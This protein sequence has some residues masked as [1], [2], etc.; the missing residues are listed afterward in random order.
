MANGGAPGFAPCW[1]AVTRW[2][3][4]HHLIAKPRPY[5]ASPTPA[6]LVR[7]G[8]GGC[9]H[10]PRGECDQGGF[11]RRHQGGFER[12]HAVESCG[13]S[14]TY[15][16]I[17]AFAPSFADRCDD[18]PDR[19]VKSSVKFNVHKD[20]PAPI[21]GERTAVAP[22]HRREPC[23]SRRVAVLGRRSPVCC[24][25]MPLARVCATG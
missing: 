12:R 24:R 10:Q 14:I 8:T 23:K 20:I 5:A 6:A 21:R 2:H 3:D 17:H 7:C 11:E 9:Q 4:E 25:L 19:R 16:R 18:G 15:R 22:W 13:S 1:S